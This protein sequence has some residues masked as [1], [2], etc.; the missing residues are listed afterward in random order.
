MDREGWERHEQSKE[1]AAP[2]TEEEEVLKGVKNAEAE[3]QRGTAAK[4]AHF[5]TGASLGI[6]LE[7][8]RTLGN[9]REGSGDNLVQLVRE[10]NLNTKVK[11]N[12]Y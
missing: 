11:V 8:R 12:G 9:L 1:V 3:A 4:R 5:G 10:S 7:V 2:L 6:E